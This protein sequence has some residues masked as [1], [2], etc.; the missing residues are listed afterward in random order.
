MQRRL[1]RGASLALLPLAFAGGAFSYYSNVIRLKLFGTTIQRAIAEIEGV[2]GTYRTDKAL[3]GS[4]IV[5]VDL[6][7]SEIRPASI[8]LVAKLPHLRT[9]SLLETPL[10]DADMVPLSA[11]KEL[12]TLESDVDPR[13]GTGSGPS[14]ADGSAPVPEPAGK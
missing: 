9:L 1:V 6:S 8:E 3:P 7:F 12:R 14:P 2:N 11:L 4:P 5:K 10:T 13:P